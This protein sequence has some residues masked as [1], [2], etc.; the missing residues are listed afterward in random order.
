[1]LGRPAGLPDPLVGVLPDLARAL[2]LGG[3][4]RPHLRRDRAIGA[5][6]DESESTS[7]PYT[8]FCCWSK[9]PLPIR[10]GFAPP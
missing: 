8:S 5:G 6:V 4:D 1:M 9:A 2:D 10:T 7:A 3:D